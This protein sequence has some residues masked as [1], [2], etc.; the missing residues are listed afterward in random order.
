MGWRRLFWSKGECEAF[1]EWQTE[2]YEHEAGRRR[3]ETQFKLASEGKVVRLDIGCGENKQGGFVGMDVRELPGVDVIWNAEDFPWPIP[4]DSVMMAMASHLVEHIE[5]H[6]GVFLR[7]MD[8]AWRV[9]MIGAQFAI[10]HPHAYSIGYA[11]DPTHANPCNFET[12]GYFAP[13]HPS[14]LWSIYRPSPWKLCHLSGSPEGNVEVLL[15][16]IECS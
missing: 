1:L 8:E 2:R 9:L 6:G 12:W 13:E 7:F 5:P 4:D 14:K 3:A 11:M 10:S 15:E 16:K